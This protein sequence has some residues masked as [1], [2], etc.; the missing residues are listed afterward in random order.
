MAR[1]RGNSKTIRCTGKTRRTGRDFIRDTS[2]RSGSEAPYGNEMPLNRTVLRA[3]LTALLAALLAAPVIYKRLAGGS[4]GVQ[5]ADVANALVHYGFHLQESAQAAGIHFV[6]TAPKLDA[7]L[8][9]IMEQV[10]S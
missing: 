2:H 10:A 7:K 5:Q 1:G 8:N 4:R 3:S 6:H 9:H